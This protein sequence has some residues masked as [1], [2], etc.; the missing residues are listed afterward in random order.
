MKEIA[1]TVEPADWSA[2]WRYWCCTWRSANGDE[3]IGTVVAE[4]IELVDE[5]PLLLMYFRF[6]DDLNWWWRCARPAAATTS[7]TNCAT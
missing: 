2:A 7:G 1:T 4:G 6:P 5:E 3:A